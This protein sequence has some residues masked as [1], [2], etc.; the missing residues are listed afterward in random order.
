MA[1]EN[2]PSFFEMVNTR[3]VHLNAMVQ[4]VSAGLIA[5]LVIFVAT[6]W[7]VLKGGNVVGPH[8]SLLNQYFIGY[9]V[10]FVG[11]L[12][13]FVYGFVLAFSGGYFAA[14]I[15]NLVV[16]IRKGGRQGHA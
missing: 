9:S 5:G 14:R 12:V 3:V 10:T 6:N 8:L 16:D 1:Q 13:G 15:Y 7:L 4:G 11:S 2:Q